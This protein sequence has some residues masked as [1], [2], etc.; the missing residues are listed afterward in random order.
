MRSKSL[1]ILTAS[2][3]GFCVGASAQSVGSSLKL[4]LEAVT[5][6]GPL[7]DLKLRVLLE[8]DAPR[9]LPVY[10]DP[11]LSPF[12]IRGRGVARLVFDVKSTT[13]GEGF[14]LQNQLPPDVVRLTPDRLLLLDCGSVYGRDI[15]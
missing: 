5:S 8:N 9:C 2:L 6:A 4:T 15:R 10:V 7:R 14:D 1:I 3:L 12:V 11:L 13:T